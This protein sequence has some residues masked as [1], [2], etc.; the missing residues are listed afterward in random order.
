MSDPMLLWVTRSSPFNLRTSRGLT[1]RG[2]RA[3]TV[4]V[5]Q[6]RWA[7]SIRPANE[8][9]AIVFTSV[10]AICY[11]Q[12][13]QRWL[14]LPVFAI[15][16]H[17]AGLAR[18]RGYSD[19]RSADGSLV[20]LRN[21]VLRSVSRVG[22]VVHFGARETAGDL[23]A[24]LRSAGLSA[25]L[26]IVYE[27]VEAAPDQLESVAMGLPF[28]EGIVVHS[29]KG[30]RVAANL[31]RKTGWHG[32]V[33]ALTRA[34]AAPFENLPGIL[35]QTAPRPTESSL[36]SLIDQFRLSAAFRT[37]GGMQIPQDLT[38]DPHRCRPATFI[39]LV[40]SNGVRCPD[41]A[42]DHSAHEP[43][44]PPPAVA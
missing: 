16:P 23:V 29:P 44:D 10:H 18:A 27:S 43:E 7:E 9:T 42:N 25:E 33:F 17:C 20:K 39:R 21:L 14:S 36:M 40:A 5:L 30:A 34:C 12:P 13:E 26:S 8:P 28:V 11:R 24:D 41:G 37:D 3:I 19:V 38:N 15:G 31:V 4:P 32:I 1:D 6:I 35:P 22:H 2:H